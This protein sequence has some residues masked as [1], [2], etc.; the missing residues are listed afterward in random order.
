MDLQPSPPRSWLDPC[1]VVRPS[2]IDRLGLFATA[3]IRAGERVIIWGGQVIGDDAIPAL[4]ATFCATGAEYS[5]AA[6]GAGLNLLQDADDPLRYGNHSCD[7]NLWL[8]DATT[9]AARRDIAA[10][11]ELTFDYA[12]ATVIASWRMDCHCGSLLC[13]SIITGDDWRRPDLRARYH[14]HF[15]PFINARIRQLEQQ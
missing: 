4:E 2:P 5:C 11:E 8:I 7:P 10:G 13:R 1:I 9:E 15:S 6:I 12:T 3:P 14:G